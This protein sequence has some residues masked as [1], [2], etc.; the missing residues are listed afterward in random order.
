MAE[1]QT[2]SVPVWKPAFKCAFADDKLIILEDLTEFDYS[3]YT[4]KKLRFV[5]SQ[6][7][8]ISF[9]S[10]LGTFPGTF[11]QEIGNY[12]YNE[13][14]LLAQLAEKGFDTAYPEK[15]LFIHIDD[16]KAKIAQQEQ[17]Y[18]DAQGQPVAF[19]FETFRD[20]VFKVYYEVHSGGTSNNQLQT[21]YKRVL[22]IN[23]LENQFV[24]LIND[25]F[26]IVTDDFDDDLEY[27]GFK[28]KL[29]K[30]VILKELL[31]LEFARGWYGETV[32]KIRAL[33]GLINDGIAIFKRGAK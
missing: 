16:V 7:N 4:R 15:L 19:L 20:D 30:F 9:S 23:T 25:Y 26:E 17:T 33:Q 1:P 24:I 2:L 6:D 10:L 29:L 14:Y 32:N 22:N 21:E 13:S 27:S 11:D 5:D 28:A 8:T 31:N 3:Y 18:L 12:N